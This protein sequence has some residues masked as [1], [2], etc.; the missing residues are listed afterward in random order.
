MNATQYYYNNDVIHIDVFSISEYNENHDGVDVGF[1]LNILSP[2][3]L[4][5]V[6]KDQQS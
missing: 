2:S 5:L 1:I 6:S 4:D 3:F